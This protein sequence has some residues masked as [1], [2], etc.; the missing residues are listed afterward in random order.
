MTSTR[1]AG[2]LISGIAVLTFTAAQS[3]DRPGMVLQGDPLGKL[4][5]DWGLSV[6]VMGGGEFGGLRCGTSNRPGPPPVTVAPPSGGA[7]SFSVSC[8]GGRDYAFRLS[9]DSTTHAYAVTVTSPPP[10][11]SVQDLP[12]AYA[13]GKGWQGKRDEQVDGQTQ[14]ITALIAPIEG[15]NWY[16]W[17]IAVLPTSGVGREND[18]KKPFLR[19]DLTR[20]K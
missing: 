8:E 18:L 19:A 15:R 11:I 10:G 3:A 1:I 17:M 14:S 6:F 20:R 4:A 16:G 7:V 12:V 2:A 13:D 9:Q 5:G